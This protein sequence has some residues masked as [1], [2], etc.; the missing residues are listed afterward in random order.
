[1]ARTSSDTRN[2]TTLQ[3]PEQWKT[4]DEPA[5]TAQRSYLETLT[6]EANEEWD[7]NRSWTKSEAAVQIEELQKKTGRG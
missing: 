6:R 5:T 2:D 7:P 3:H 4:G 1:M